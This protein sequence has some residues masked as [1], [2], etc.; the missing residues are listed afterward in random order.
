MGI[1]QSIENP[2]SIMKC[3]ACGHVWTPGAISA[4]PVRARLTPREAEVV[5]LIAAGKTNKDVAIALGLREN[6]VR[7]YLVRI[8]EKLG[9]SSRL[10]VAM[11]AARDA[12]TSRNEAIHDVMSHLTGSAA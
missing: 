9:A 10:Q 11:H 1:A 3:A 12:A 6:T 8:F 2:T 7:N 5:S 4:Q